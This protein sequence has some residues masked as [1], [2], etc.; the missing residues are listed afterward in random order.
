VVAVQQVQV[1]AVKPVVAV[2]QEQV[3]AVQPVVAVQKV[4]VIAVQPVVEV[5]PVVEVQPVVEVHQVVLLISQSIA[6]SRRFGVLALLAFFVYYIFTVVATDHPQWLGVWFT[7]VLFDVLPLLTIVTN[8]N[9]LH[10]KNM[11]IT[12]VIDTVYSI[13]FFYI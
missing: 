5:K 2:Q 1:I 7:A 6:T 9:K 12:R 10:A 4:Q 13:V 8:S 3:I 11:L